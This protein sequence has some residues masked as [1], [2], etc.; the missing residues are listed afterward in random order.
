[1]VVPQYPGML[2]TDKVSVTWAAAAGVPADGS[3][4]TTPVDVGTIGPKEIELPP[5][6]TAYSLGKTATVTYTVTR[7]GMPLPGS[8]PLSLAVQTIPAANLPVPLIPQAAS[9]GTGS[10][11]DLTSF[12]GNA[13]VTCAPWPLIAAG[14]RVWLRAEGIAQDGGGV[15]IITLYTASAVNSSEVSAGLVKDLL[16]SELVKL[17]DGSELKVVLQVT[18]DR[19]NVQANAV[20]FPLRTYTIRAFELVTPTIASV[21]DPQGTEI[22]NGGTTTS[23]TVTLS[24]KASTSQRVEIFDGTTSKGTADVN[25]NGDW[26]KTLTGLAVAALSFTAKGLYGSPQPVSPARTLTVREALVV[27][28][29]PMILNG[30]ALKTHLAWTRSTAPSWGNNAQRQPTKGTPPMAYVTSNPRIATVDNVG[31]VIGEANGNAQ[32][33]ITDAA[34]E[35]ATY[36]VRVSNVFHVHHNPTYLPKEGALAWFNQ[37]SI[38]ISDYPPEQA[39]LTALIITFPVFHEYMRTTGPGQYVYGY[40]WWPPVAPGSIIRSLMRNTDGNFVVLDTDSGPN[41]PTICLGPRP[42]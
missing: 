27:D 32:I 4:T 9:N 35:Q 37:T 25:A 18:F 24:G 39:W 22:P 33:T 21:K 31:T 2:A 13:R 7:D 38:P 17:R 10:A 41:D 34:G 11:L 40:A 12:T 29:S 36:E 28:P 1:A 3:A 23:T 6:L 30:L 15:H 14:Q 5:R 20:D 19:T 16:R 26:T 42:Q 8:N